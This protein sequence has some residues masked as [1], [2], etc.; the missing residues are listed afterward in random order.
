[1]S[2]HHLRNGRK[3]VE[4]IDFAIDFRLPQ[5]NSQLQHLY[6]LYFMIIVITSSNS[7]RY[8]KIASKL[9]SFSSLSIG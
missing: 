8:G 6:E 3:T 9:V 7:F 4:N 1:M 5:L 2:R